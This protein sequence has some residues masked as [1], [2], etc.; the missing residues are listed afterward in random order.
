MNPTSA[1]YS[2]N[3]REIAEQYNGLDFESV[4]QSWKL[5]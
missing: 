4:H 5:Y 2:Q 3:A 1:F